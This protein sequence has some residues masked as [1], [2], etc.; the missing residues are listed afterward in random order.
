MVNAAVTQLTQ[1]PAGPAAGAAA[2]Q[3]AP[4]PKAFGVF[5]DLLNTCLEDRPAAKADGQT[6]EN[7]VPTDL[8]ALL[9]APPVLAGTPT[10]A[11]ATQPTPAGDQ[12]P[13]GQVAAADD[14]PIQTGLGSQMRLV[15]LVVE[16]ASQAVAGPRAARVDPP[17]PAVAQG[18]TSV[19]M[20]AGA[21]SAPTP[22]TD[23]APWTRPVVLQPATTAAAPLAGE[24][25]VTVSGGNGS[26]AKPAE[27]P[28]SRPSRDARVPRTE[29][30]DEQAATKVTLVQSLPAKPTDWGRAPQVA[31]VTAYAQDQPADNAKPSAQPDDSPDAAPALARAETTSRPAEI[32]PARSTQAAKPD[33]ELNQRVIDQVVR[34]VSLHRFQDRTD[35]VVKLNPPELGSLSVRIVQDAQGMTSQIQATSENVRSLLQAHL[36]L[37]VDALSDAGVRLNS[38][39]VTSNASFTAL[40]HDSTQGSAQRQYETP[41][42]HSGQAQDAVGAIDAVGAADFIDSPASLLR[43]AGYSWLA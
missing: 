35:L 32:V 5:G 26:S 28:G 20:P 7:S 41:Q 16:D 10:T 34:A 13:G 39:T 6:A 3:N 12:G 31:E 11:P 33:A 38:V 36:P 25:V 4:S 1:G 2:D 15:P 18:E 17:A 40:T 27:R 21:Q 19:E 42:R 8:C 23:G 30:N 43:S 14:L 22:A 37:L 24:P 29:P 9:F